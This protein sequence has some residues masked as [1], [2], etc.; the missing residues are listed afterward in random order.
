[1]VLVCIYKHFESD[2]TV[3]TRSDIFY[4][5]WSNPFVPISQSDLALVLSIDFTS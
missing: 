1:M 5:S 4:F 2:F 3:V